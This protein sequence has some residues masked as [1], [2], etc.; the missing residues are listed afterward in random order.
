MKT[1]KRYAIDLTS[2]S[3]E[4]R[5]AM[6]AKIRLCSDISEEKFF[7]QTGDYFVIFFTTDLPDLLAAIPG[8]SS[9]PC[10]DVTGFRD[11]PSPDYLR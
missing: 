8:I 1:Y 6:Y 2:L 5:S 7:P 9:L 10:K 4:N 11:F 3:V